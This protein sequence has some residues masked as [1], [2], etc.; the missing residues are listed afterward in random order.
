[1]STGRYYFI[2][3]YDHFKQCRANK[4]YNESLIAEYLAQDPRTLFGIKE[5]ANI[6]S[7]QYYRRIGD[8]GYTTEVSGGGGGGGGVNVDGAVAGGL[9]FGPTGAIIGGQVGTEIK[10]D[11]IQSRTV[12]H[13][14]RKTLLRLKDED[15]SYEELTLPVKYYDALLKLLPEKDYEQVMESHKRD[16]QATSYTE[17]NPLMDVARQIR[18][19]KELLDIGAITVEEFEKKKK[20]L[21]DT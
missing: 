3:Q 17:E 6:D 8:I 7:I 19:F 20:Q 2:P 9:L 18:D 10:I 11:A 21:L 12:K 13:D 5:Y 16:A 1:M 15:G 4:E 14:D